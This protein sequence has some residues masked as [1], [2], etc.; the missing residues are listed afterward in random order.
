M[1]KWEGMKVG[2]YEGGEKVSLIYST[3]LG[4]RGGEMNYFDYLLG[5]VRVG[6]IYH[7]LLLW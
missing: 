1:R 3:G 7:F 2:R 5:K 6:M 4:A